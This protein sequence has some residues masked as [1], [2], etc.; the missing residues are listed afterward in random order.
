MAVLKQVQENWF[1]D[2][3]Q[4]AGLDPTHFKREPFRGRDGDPNLFGINHKASSHFFG[5]SPG[6]RYDT[7]LY[8]EKRGW[9]VIRAPGREEFMD[10][11]VAANWEG[12]QQLFVEWLNLLKEEISQT[13]LWEAIQHQPALGQLM[14]AED[15]DNT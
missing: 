5:T 8:G 7:G 13:D 3:I 4:G 1:V 10:R 2:A 12:A 6:Y 15:T 14:R 11:I 9:L